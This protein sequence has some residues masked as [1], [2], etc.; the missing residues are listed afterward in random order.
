[1]TAWISVK[2]LLPPDDTNVAVLYIVNKEEFPEYLCF[3]KFK[4]GAFQLSSGEVI[5]WMPIQSLIDNVD[6]LLDIKQRANNE[7]D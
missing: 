3:D 5:R 4:D 7:L 1:M 2:D 6:C